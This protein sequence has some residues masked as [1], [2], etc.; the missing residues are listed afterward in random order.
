MGTIYTQPFL[1]SDR[2]GPSAERTVRHVA[3]FFRLNRSGSRAM[4][5]GSGG[6]C[7]RLLRQDT[8]QALGQRW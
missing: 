2:G 7:L 8:G 1:A 6:H 4:D 3:G 5:I